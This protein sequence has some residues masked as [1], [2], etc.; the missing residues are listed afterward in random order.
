[1]LTLLPTKVSAASIEKFVLF[2]KK[3]ALAKLIAHGKQL[4]PHEQLQLRLD[5][6]FVGMGQNGV[7][8]KGSK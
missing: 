7:L 5:T 3:R 4:T 6:V 1:M 8:S 2:C